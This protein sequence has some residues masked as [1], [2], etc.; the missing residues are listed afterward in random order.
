MRHAAFSHLA[1]LEAS[2]TNL[3]RSDGSDSGKMVTL[4][5]ENG[6]TDV[7]TTVQWW[8]LRNLNPVGQAQVNQSSQSSFR[9]YVSS[10]P[11]PLDIFALFAGQG[12]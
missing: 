11:V 8:S 10:L 6:Q 3:I 4:A 7:N 2:L 1:V 12:L 5:L 9:I